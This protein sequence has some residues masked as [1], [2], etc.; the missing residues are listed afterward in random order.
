ME[1][2][3]REVSSN[4]FH[5]N[6]TTTSC[7]YYCVRNCSLSAK[8]LSNRVLSVALSLENA[9]SIPPI[10][11]EAQFEAVA[12]SSLKPINY[13]ICLIIPV[14]RHELFDLKSVVATVEVCD[15]VNPFLLNFCVASRCNFTGPPHS[16]VA[17]LASEEGA[18][19][20]YYV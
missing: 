20:S 4:R 17:G 15:L 8:Y 19:R 13:S 6:S 11:I 18:Q 7:G 16:E 1:G 5:L 14:R 9:K 3:T 12:E 2:R 10:L